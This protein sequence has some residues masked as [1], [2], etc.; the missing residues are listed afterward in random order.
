MEKRY[1]NRVNEV[2][3]GKASFRI[4]VEKILI[5]LE[6][7]GKIAKLNSHEHDGMY[8]TQVADRD[9]VVNEFRLIR[10]LAVNLQPNMNP[11]AQYEQV[12]AFLE[13]LK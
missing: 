1:N 9:G 2:L 7:G 10:P 12:Q 11:Q 13:S 6:Q 4:E 3:E 8:L 5:L